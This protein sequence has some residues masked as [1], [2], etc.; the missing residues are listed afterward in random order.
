MI[1]QAS[2]I[3]MLFFTQ[4]AFFVILASEINFFITISA[5]LSTTIVCLAYWFLFYKNNQSKSHS[6]VNFYNPISIIRYVLFIVAEIC[7]SSITIIKS[8]AKKQKLEA[9]EL[10]Y[11]FKN[12][13]FHKN[14][15]LL[16]LFI[17]TTTITPGTIFDNFCKETNSL[18]INCVFDKKTH[19]IIYNDLETLENNLLRIFNV[20]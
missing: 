7:K 8:M 14:E 18:I 16:Y 1:N 11:T 2:K 3:I 12:D 13:I 10:K 20:L 15:T 5:L 4:F 17:F 6:G 9:I 19:E